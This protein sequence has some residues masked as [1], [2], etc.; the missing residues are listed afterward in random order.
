MASRKLINVSEIAYDRF[1][2]MK[3]PGESFTDLIIRITS[4]SRL[5]DL[6]G[7]VSVKTADILMDTY[8]ESRR[9]DGEERLNRVMSGLEE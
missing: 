9:D 3:Q 2:R 1:S 5:L 6:A 7:I 8:L 4:K